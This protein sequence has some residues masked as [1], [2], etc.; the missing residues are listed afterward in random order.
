MRQQAQAPARSTIPSIESQSSPGICTS[1][2]SGSSLSLKSM[3]EIPE[4]SGSKNNRRSGH[5][6]SLVPRRR[7]LR[8]AGTG[9]T[10]CRQRPRRINIDCQSRDPPLGPPSHA[11]GLPMSAATGVRGWRS[12]RAAA[13]ITV[14]S[15]ASRKQAGRD[16]VRHES[17]QQ[18][19]NPAAPHC[20]ILEQSQNYR[21]LLSILKVAA[22][23][24]HVDLA[25]AASGTIHSG[26][27]MTPPAFTA[28]PTGLLRWPAHSASSC[29]RN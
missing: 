8:K 19:S 17:H 10:E 18:T 6:R 21:G 2:L 28:R 16:A 3:C 14:R 22:P 1:L 7:Y 4:R 15:G 20:I 5:A 11:R 25:S 9:Q 29:M 12:R 26:F 13:K 23:W 24:G 27:A